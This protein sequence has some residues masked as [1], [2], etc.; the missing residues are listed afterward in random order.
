MTH[1]EG[2]NWVPVASE[3]EKA[4]NKPESIYSELSKETIESILSKTVDINAPGTAFSVVCSY[5]PDEWKDR[6]D[7]FNQKIGSPPSIEEWF[8]KEIV[9]DHRWDDYV[10]DGVPNALD[11]YR[12]Y[13]GYISVASEMVSKD[14]DSKQTYEL[15]DVITKMHLSIDN[16]ISE[17]EFMKKFA[18]AF[19]SELTKKYI[20]SLAEKEKSLKEN[21]YGKDFESF[22][23]KYERELHS[24][25]SEYLSAHNP[26]DLFQRYEDFL[27]DFKYWRKDR[28][29][30]GYSAQLRWKKLGIS[31]YYDTHQTPEEI[32]KKEFLKRF[33]VVV[34]EEQ[35]VVGAYAKYHEDYD[36]TSKKEK[37][38]SPLKSILTNGIFGGRRWRS[39]GPNALTGYSEEP[40]QI[41]P[42]VQTPEAYVQDIRTKNE[43]ERRRKERHVFF[44]IVGQ[45][46]NKDVPHGRDYPRYPLEYEEL[47][48]IKM[49]DCYW[50]KNNS[51]SIIFDKKGMEYTT[52]DP[53]LSTPRSEHGYAGPT[54]VAPRKFSGIVVSCTDSEKC[55]RSADDIA[56]VM[57]ETNANHPD[58][59]I[60]IYDI[61]GNMLWPTNVTYE[62]IQKNKNGK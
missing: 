32:S 4:S 1:M 27:K 52:D 15:R 30:L 36:E 3:K 40:N 54:R 45:F 42:L 2:Y 6:V 53:R 34:K 10:T 55:Q 39:S 38:L 47:K 43:D 37:A 12:E 19:S 51:V 61:S 13:L 17:Q 21:F 57:I 25:D 62:E 7:N 20:K 49:K 60:P 9:D 22:K 29:S 16:P 58:R 50:I 18:G 41:E 28:R 46:H 23:R 56:R 24:R 48:S 8:S 44:N 31:D 59:L 5:Y 26:E 11:I 14:N 33:D 35:D